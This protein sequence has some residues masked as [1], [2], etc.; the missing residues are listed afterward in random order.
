MGRRSPLSFTY[1]IQARMS[2]LLLFMHETAC[3]R[4]LA[5]LKA[6]NSMAAK[7][8]M[9]AMTTSNSI[10]VKAEERGTEAALIGFG[11]MLLDHPGRLSVC[12]APKTSGS[13]AFQGFF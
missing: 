10:R 13:L 1:M 4:A 8:A 2:C 7:I 12:T 11:I 5:R 6:G 9:I 3:A